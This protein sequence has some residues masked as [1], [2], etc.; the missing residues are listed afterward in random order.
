[1]LTAALC[2]AVCV[3][4]A[5]PPGGA[6]PLAG[7]AALA[8]FSGTGVAAYGDASVDGQLGAGVSLAA[9]AVA[10]ASTPDGR[11]YWVAA[12]DGGVFSFGDASY[13]SSLGATALYA[14]VVGMAATPDGGGYWLVAA[15][16]GVFSFGNAVFHGSMG[17]T[18]LAQP[19]VGMAAT[20]DGGGY[21]LVAADGGIFSFGDAV[22]HGS[23]GA[24]HLNEPVNAMAST[25][26]GGGYW[27]V[28]ADG[29]VFTFGDAVFHGSAANAKIGTSVSGIAA[30]S[31][32]GGYWLAAATAGVL[33]FGD[34]VSYG[35]TP[36]T[37]PFPPTAAIAATPDGKG[38]WLLQPDS[39]PTAFIAPFHPA[40]GPGGQSIVQAAATQIGPDPDAGR[41]PFCNPYGP[42]EEWCA[43]FATWAWNQIGIAI[44]RLAFVGAVYGWAAA[45]GLVLPGGSV[46]AP[47][48][49]VFYGTGPQSVVSSP[50]MAVVAEVWPDGAITTV[51]GDSGP[52]PYGRY[53]VTFNGP[54]L[55]RFLPERERHAR[56]RL[57]PAVGIASISRGVDQ[58][59]AERAM[60]A[61]PLMKGSGLEV[62]DSTMALMSGT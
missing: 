17:A 12:A 29:G 40:N 43:L 4:G 52:E 23:M 34:A 35:P 49:F 7:P 41:G 3:V 14:P 48:D 26:D 39:L 44:P 59:A 60:A 57:R 22:F 11:G 30:T 33:T 58:R 53:A 1:M 13:F 38:Y 54:F 45:R 61:I 42:C 18:P 62:L 36:N 8:G 15:D 46:P 16:G 50:H 51:D 31:D 6:A 9:P 19:V 24:K 32:D 27:L 25:H 10:M 55:P 5:A 2:G 20:P 47:G 37:A 28:A 56:L 21:W